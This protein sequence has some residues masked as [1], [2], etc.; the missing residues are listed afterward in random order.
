MIAFSCLS[1]ISA[2]TRSAFVARENRFLL[3]RIMLVA[4]LRIWMRRPHCR[5]VEGGSSR[6]GAPSFRM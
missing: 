2:Q 6:Y 5:C 1:M 3:F 4:P